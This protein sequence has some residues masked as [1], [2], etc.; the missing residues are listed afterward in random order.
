MNKLTHIGA[1]LAPVFARRARA[2]TFHVLYPQ[3][4][5]SL[6]PLA[7]RGL[8]CGWAKDANGQ[9]SCNWSE[10]RAAD[11]QGAAGGAEAA[12][13][14]KPCTDRRGFGPAGS[15]RS[16]RHRLP[17]WRAAAVSHARAA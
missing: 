6:V 7:R 2:A 16:A 15:R 14:E 3:T 13:E 9:L 8:S 4:R 17:A 12:P 11:P 1:S 10:A 5:A